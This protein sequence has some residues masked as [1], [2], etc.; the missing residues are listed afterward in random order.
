MRPSLTQ[1]DDVIQ[2]HLVER[3]ENAITHQFNATASFVS[4][5]NSSSVDIFYRTVSKFPRTPDSI[6]SRI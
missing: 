1:R 3:Y 5:P 2:M 4:T 6:V